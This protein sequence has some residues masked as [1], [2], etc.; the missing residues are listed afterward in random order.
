MHILADLFSSE[1]R[2]HKK[3]RN[4]AKSRHEE[5]LNNDPLCSRLDEH[6]TD[7]FW[8]AL[9]LEICEKKTTKEEGNRYAFLCVG[10]LIDTSRPVI[11][12]GYYCI[13]SGTPNML[14]KKTNRSIT[15][16]IS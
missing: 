2:G 5:D 15:K 16:E 3:E 9:F 6:S 11:V 1:I 7:S 4:E 14:I 8:E 13:I 10:F 12:R